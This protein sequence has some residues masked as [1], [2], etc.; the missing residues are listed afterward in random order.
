MSM[1][2]FIFQIHRETWWE[3]EIDL[4]RK[5]LHTVRTLLGWM[6]IGVPLNDKNLML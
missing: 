4:L 2:N 3:D 6:V 5:V 1:D